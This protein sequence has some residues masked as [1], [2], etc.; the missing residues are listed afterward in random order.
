MFT[1][2]VV[3]NDREDTRP[4]T[5]PTRHGWALVVVG[6]VAGLLAQTSYAQPAG[7]APQQDVQSQ[8]DDLRSRLDEL[9]ST[10]VLSEPETRVR[11][12]EVWVDE[13]GTQYDQEMP[14]TEMVVTYQ[15]ER[16]YRRQLV[17]EKI[18]AALDDAAANSVEVGVDA[19][20]TLQH[21]QQDTG[22][23]SI[24]DGNTYQLASADLFF[25][26]G[27]AQYTVFF[28]DI[29]GLSGTPPDA[30]IQ[31]LNLL[32]GYTARLVN[33]NELN[34]REAWLMTELVDQKLMLTAGRVDLTAFF[35][36]NAVANDESSQF[37]SDPLVNNP[38]LGLSENGAGLAAV[39]DPRNGFSAKFGYQQSSS[40][41]TNLSDSLFYLAEVSQLFNPFGLGEGNY[42]VWY[43]KDNSSGVNR[44]GM[45]VSIDQRVSPG[46]V[47]FAR[48][49]AAETDIEDDDR[50][51]SAGLE[52]HNALTFNPDDYWGMGVARTELATNDQELLLESYY[53]FQMTE[54][55]TMTVHLTHVTEEP[56]GAEETSYFVPGLR[57]QASF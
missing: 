26:A 57:V 13:N 45:G 47:L 30:E 8:I 50:F 39:F 46:V 18:E 20:I 4:N 33:Q 21:A 1:V 3:P 32:N 10:A 48:Y 54:K 25:T 9:E 11:R 15:R 12:I 49:G 52:L 43:R 29:V 24:A 19:A 41:A 2:R 44:T 34:L 37:L 42:R 17:N 16:V 28:A 31:G 6:S 36:H 14:G 5:A 7:Q 35:D 53:K 51:Y 56:V 23:D 22:P 38:M 55:L 27:I 40:T